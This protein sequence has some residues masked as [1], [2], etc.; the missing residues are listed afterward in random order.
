M[1]RKL[2]FGVGINDADYRVIHSKS[3]GSVNGKRIRKIVWQCPYFITWTSVMRRSFSEVYKRANPSYEDVTCC[4][5]WKLFS[6]FRAWMVTQDHEGLHLDKDILFGGS[7]IY[8]PEKCAFVPQEVNT[9]LLDCNASRGEYP[10]GVCV[11][12]D[13]KNPYYIAQVCKDRKGSSHIGCYQSAGEAHK[14]WQWEKAVVIESV[15]GWYAKQGCFR[16][17]IAEA[18]TYKVWK[19]RTDHAQGVETK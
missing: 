19:L 12:L 1:T 11:K 18:L 17:D 5:D 6:N 13:R 8:S 2:S 7:K 9:L 14:A 10:I 16:A 3:F 15:V 4:E